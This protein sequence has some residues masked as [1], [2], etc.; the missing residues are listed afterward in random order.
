MV[1]YGRCPIDSSLT[2]PFA[3]PDVCEPDCVLLGTGR[4]L[5]HLLL[6]YPIVGKGRISREMERGKQYFVKNLKVHKY[7]VPSTCSTRYEGEKLYDTPPEGTEKCDNCFT[8][9]PR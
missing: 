8:G 6:A 2:C 1:P 7:P 5:S 3:D 9:L 4:L